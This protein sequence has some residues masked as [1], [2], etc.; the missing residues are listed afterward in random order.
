MERWYKMRE[1]ERCNG[2][3]FPGQNNTGDFAE[4]GQG[5]NLEAIGAPLEK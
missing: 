3:K 4:H 1:G 5:L 2:A